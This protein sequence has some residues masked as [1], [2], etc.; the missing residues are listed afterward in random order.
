MP[1]IP[2]I[3]VAILLIATIFQTSVLGSEDTEGG[4]YH[5]EPENE[6][7]NIAP[8]RYKKCESLLERQEWYVII[9]S[10]FFIYSDAN[11]GI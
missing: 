4:D 9:V 6:T 11:V 10:I 5:L 8:G 2:S 3:F 1:S 7:G